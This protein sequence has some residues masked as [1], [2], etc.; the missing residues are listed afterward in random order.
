MHI[1][2]L[3]NMDE[4]KIIIISYGYKALKSNVNLNYNKKK[5]VLNLITCA[6]L[7]NK[8]HIITYKCP[9]FGMWLNLEDI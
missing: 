5:N 7:Q 8:C 6:M 3:E 1:F 4:S 2:F 9:P